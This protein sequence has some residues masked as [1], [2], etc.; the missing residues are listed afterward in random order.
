MLASLT[1]LTNALVPMLAEFKWD[2]QARGII[3]VMV[4]V[5]ILPGSVFMLLATNVGAR[6]G[7]LL[8]VAGLSGWCTLMGSLWWVNAQGLKGR[9]PSWKPMEIVVGNPGDSILGER[10]GLPASAGQLPTG[11]G[12]H[13]LAVGQPTLGDATAAADKVLAPDNSPAPEG[14]KKP[15]PK[16]TPPFTKSSDYVLIGAYEKGA[17][18]DGIWFSIRHHHFFKAGSAKNPLNW[19]RQQPHY[20][21]MTVEAIRPKLNPNDVTEKFKPDLSKPPRTL[22][23]IR[24]RGSIRFPPVMVTLGSFLIFCSTCYSLHKRDL[25][26]QA[27]KGGARAVAA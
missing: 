24:D 3:I 5:A 4:I 10:A 2:P 11:N 23:L 20:V 15:E 25:E 7:F 9:P 14:H 19:F 6:L 21:V 27:R 12:W 17:K 1:A 26:I 18:T 8:A 16:F 13:Q 22:T